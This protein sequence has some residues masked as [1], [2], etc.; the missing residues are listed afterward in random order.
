MS[1]VSKFVWWSLALLVV[2]GICG[3]QAAWNNQPSFSG[4]TPDFGYWQQKYKDIAYELATTPDTKAVIQ[5]APIEVEQYTLQQFPFVVNDGTAQQRVDR[6]ES[7]HIGVE[8]PSMTA[9]NIIK[10]VDHVTVSATDVPSYLD[11]HPKTRDIVYTLGVHPGKGVAVTKGELSWAVAVN[12]PA[13]PED[14]QKQILDARLTS[15]HPFA[16]YGCTTCH[17]GSGRELVQNKAHGD[18]EFWLQPML[19]SKYQEAACAQ[20]HQKFDPKTFASVYLPEMTTIAH[21]QQLFK[22]NACWGCHKIEGFSKGN[23]GPELT[24]E[25]RIT[26]FYSIEHQLYDPRYKVNNCIMPY[27]FSK[28]VETYNYAPDPSKPDEILSVATLYDNYGK[29]MKGPDGKPFDPDMFPRAEVQSDDTT[30]SLAD[31]GYI[32]DRSRQTD[33]DALVTF[34]TAQTGLNYAQDRAGRLTR[35]TAYNSSQPDTV[36]VTAAQGKILFEQSGCT[37]CH[38]LG[39]PDHPEKGKGGVAGPNLSWEGS[40]HSQQW[41]IAHYVNPQAF[42]PK[43]IMPIFPFSD[44]QRAALAL[45]DSSSKPKGS[46]AVSPDQDMPSAGALKDDI[47]DPQVRY[48]TR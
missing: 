6:C 43:S 31:H 38:Y 10:T 40:R 22:Q 5:S 47:A 15:Q 39:D 37:A 26:T 27:F 42:V 34:I 18:S 19:P 46:K 32:P 23:V 29:V 14:K 25:G 21:G 8:N 35:I 1:I 48:M 7:C 30:T 4:G 33:V 13:L 16:T 24:Y 44:S 11:Q 41:M 36:P 12:N 2:V 45:Y 17:Y 20:C 9:E 28:K 3:Y